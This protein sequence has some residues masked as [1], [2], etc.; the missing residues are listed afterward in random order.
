MK[1]LL[2]LF[3]LFPCLALAD[4]TK[5]QIEKIDD[6][7]D[8][9]ETL[10][11]ST[12]N[13]QIDSW[14]TFGYNYTWIPSPQRVEGFINSYDGYGNDSILT[15]WTIQEYTDM[16][17]EETRYRMINSILD[18]DIEQFLVWPDTSP[19]AGWRGFCLNGRKYVLCPQN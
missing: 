16:V 18:E 6:Y 3:F 12:G 10:I 2:F 5:K 1:K 7:Q 9:L 19:P 13:I 11:L 4:P 14:Q 15:S 8:I 17:Y